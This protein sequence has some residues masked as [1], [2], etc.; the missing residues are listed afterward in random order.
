MGNTRVVVI[1]GGYAGT[2]AANRL[3]QRPDLEITLVNPRPVFVERIRLHQLVAD[4]GAATADY[5]TLLGEGIQ[6]VVD[7]VERIDTADRRLL[8][9]SGIA[10]AYDYLGST[11]VVPAQEAVPGAAEFAHSICDLESAQR[12]RY[13]L[14]DLPLTAPVTVVGVRVDGH[15]N[16]GRAGRAG[17]SG[18]AGVRWRARGVAEQ[19]GPPFGGQ[20][21]APARGHHRRNRGRRRGPLGQRGAQR[22]RSAAQRGNRVDRRVH[23]AGPGRP[24]RAAHRR[25]GL[26]ARRRDADQHRRRSHRRRG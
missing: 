12:L 20:A 9:T 10:L 5:G 2:L 26:A 22:R 7:A 14:A 19:P 4:T 23:R 3:R 18:D 25:V 8:L 13:A 6:L 1:G 16:G 24:Q 17:S 11:G 15:R 21:T